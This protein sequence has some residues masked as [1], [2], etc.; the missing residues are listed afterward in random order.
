MQV[1]KFGGTSVAN[2]ENIAKA[3]AVIC[4]AAD[5]GK[6]F[7]VVSALGGTTD[8][9]I[10][11]GKPAAAGN[12]TYKDKLKTIENRH[13]QTI[14]EL[15]AVTEQSSI[16]SAIKK[17]CNDLESVCEGVYL[18]RELTPRSLDKIVSFG[19]L[20]SSMIISH[21][22]KTE[23]VE[24]VWKDSR[25]VIFT[26]SDFTHAAVDFPKTDFAILTFVKENPSSLY[27]FRVSLPAIQ[28]ELL[29]HSVEEVPIT[30][31]Q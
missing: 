23:N 16:L 4:N 25:E 11:A 12:E 21:K 26:D 30:Q 20:M 14:K 31:R 15:I 6:T 29:L 18:L 19:E 9:L 10:E 7:V 22:L 17:Q 13:L 5:K 27:L 1:L 3:V 28:T 8:V 2:A 24:H